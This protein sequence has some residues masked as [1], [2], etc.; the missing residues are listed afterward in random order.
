MSVRIED[1]AIIGDGE[2]AALLAPEIDRLA[3]LAPV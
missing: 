2:T 1:F 3:L